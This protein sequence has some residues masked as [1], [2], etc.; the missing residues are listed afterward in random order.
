MSNKQ[1]CRSTE[2]TERVKS[3][4][5]LPVCMYVYFSYVVVQK[6]ACMGHACTIKSGG[7]LI[8]FLTHTCMYS[9]I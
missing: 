7:I 5:A 1:Y 3:T 4:N 6:A 9:C 2:R 8:M